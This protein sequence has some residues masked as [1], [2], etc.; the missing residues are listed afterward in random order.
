MG[1]I[2]NM[3]WLF[4]GRLQDNLNIKYLNFLQVFSG[5]KRVFVQ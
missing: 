1:F 3:D 5:D 2:F 4:E